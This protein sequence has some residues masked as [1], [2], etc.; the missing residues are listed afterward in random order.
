ME[1]DFI[2]RVVC[3]DSVNRDV[4]VA[5]FGVVRDVCAGYFEVF[6]MEC[7]SL[8]WSPTFGPCDGYDTAECHGVRVYEK[9]EIVVFGFEV[10]E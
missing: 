3:V 2:E 6:L 4:G 9:L 5:L 1:S 7:Q 8:R 10:A